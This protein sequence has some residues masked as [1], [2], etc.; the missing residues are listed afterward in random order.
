[1]SKYYK[2]EDVI[3]AIAEQLC[4]IARTEY[5]DKFTTEDWLEEAEDY[6]SDLPTIEANEGEWVGEADGYWNGE[7][8]YD[9]WYCPFCDHCIEEDEQELLPNYCPNCGADMRGAECLSE[10]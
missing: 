7:L 9:V 10:K 6:V 1:M 4:W 8:I 5:G 2:A 3:R